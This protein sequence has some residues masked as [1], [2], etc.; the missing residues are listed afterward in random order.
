M[1][2]VVLATL[3]LLLMACSSSKYQHITLS[4]AKILHLQIEELGN[5]EKGYSRLN[6]KLDYQIEN[7]HEAKDLYRC[8]VQFLMRNGMT[9]SGWMDQDCQITR[10]SGTISVTLSTPLDKGLRAVPTMRDVTG[11]VKLPLQYFVAMLQRNGAEKAQVIGKSD[12][13]TLEMKIPPDRP[14]TAG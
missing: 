10:A 13:Q 14:G 3:G 9:A 12:F 8:T 6:V 2:S 5:H 11:G 1:K 7:F 4:T